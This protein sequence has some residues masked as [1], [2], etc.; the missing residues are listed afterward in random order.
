MLIVAAGEIRVTDG[1]HTVKGRLTAGNAYAEYALFEDHLSTN[2]LVAETYCELWCLSKRAFKVA[3]QK[4]FSKIMYASLLARKLQPKTAELT[5]RRN[6]F[7]DMEASARV[8]KLVGVGSTVKNKMVQKLTREATSAA[9]KVPAWRQP[10]STFQFVWARARCVLLLLLIAEVPHQMA[11][12]RGFGLLNSASQP[13]F[14]TVPFS[15]Q[16]AD[17]ALSLAIELFFYADLYLRARCFVRPA[18]S[19]RE[20]QAEDEL[21][22]VHAVA[23]ISDQAQIFRHFLEHDS[24]W[25]DVVAS[26]P[27]ALAWDMVPKEWFTPRVVLFVRFFRALRLLR[28]RNMKQTLK[29]LMLDHGF[30]QYSRLLVYIAAGVVSAAHCAGCLF[31]LVADMDVFQG[32]LPADGVAPGGISTPECLERA[33]LFGNCTW[34]MYDRSTFAIDAPYLRSLHWSLVLLSTVGYG[35]IVAFT[36]KECVAACVWIFVGANVCYFTGSALTSVSAQVTVL[37]AIRQDRVAEINLALTS[38]PAVSA[39]TKS[40]LRSYYETKWKLN[41]S[42]VHDEELMAHLPRSLRRRVMRALYLDDVRRC[43]LFADAST[44]ENAVLLQLLAQASRCEIFLRHTFVIREGHL[45]TEFFLVQSGDAEKLLPALNVSLPPPE[46]HS[47]P[48]RRAPRISIKMPPVGA[49]FAK[50]PSRGV[51]LKSTSSPSAIHTRSRAQLGT[52]VAGGASAP[53]PLRQFASLP[54]SSLMRASIANRQS[55]W[56]IGVRST[57]IKNPDGAIFVSVLRPGDCFGEESIAPSARR[58]VYQVSVR[59]VSTIQVVVIRR[60]DLLTLSTRFPQQ[61]ESILAR[62]KQQAAADDALLQKLRVN[63]FTKEKLSKWLG[64]TDSLLFEDT[65]RDKRLRRV[66]DP[67]TAFARWWHRAIGVVLT[68]N[69]YIIVFRV[70]FLPRPSPATMRCLTALDYCFDALLYADIYLKHQHLGFVEYGQKILDPAL[71]RKRYREGRMVQDCLSMLPLYYHG[72]YLYM[73]AARVVRLLRSPQLL[74]LLNDIHS[75]IQQHFLKGSTV[76]LNVFALIKFIL[77]FVSTAH[78]VGSLYYLLGRL[79]LASGLV[80]TSWVSADVI[81]AQHPHDPF[82]HYMRA[83]YWCLSTVRRRFSSLSLDHCGY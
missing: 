12:Q 42:A 46:A 47:S 13:V 76:L 68:Y 19:R 58:E 40:L 43:A 24:Y 39:A 27:I 78:Y 2:R 5:V 33:T 71:I 32:G 73:S 75:H 21:S 25:P 3:L 67:D 77:V 6:S 80:T 7:D 61:F 82:V 37:D 57:P 15:V 70:A 66:L 65:K 35:D 54:K 45:A 69:F 29:T 31:F 23:M 22:N 81:L 11:F 55:L 38:M 20:Q 74:T 53:P 30:A 50:Q 72:D 83:M 8:L 56:R 4:H 79:Q 49:K 10:D 34:Y 9:E 62:R 28:V 44:P 26:L 63:F 41:G 17:F 64:P 60:E 18:L 51:F 48:S 36:T 59:A 1:A 52:E 14:G 16:V